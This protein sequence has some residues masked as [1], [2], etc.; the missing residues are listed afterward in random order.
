MVVKL[1]QLIEKNSNKKFQDG[2][3][4]VSQSVTNGHKPSCIYA[5]KEIMLQVASTPM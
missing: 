2:V 4:L 3:T 5:S 1:Q